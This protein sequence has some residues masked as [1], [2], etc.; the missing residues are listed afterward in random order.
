MGSVTDSA[1]MALFLRD[2]LPSKYAPECFI[3][4]NWVAINKS[5]RYSAE[6]A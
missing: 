1:L 3:A 2:A 4:K 5:N 6:L